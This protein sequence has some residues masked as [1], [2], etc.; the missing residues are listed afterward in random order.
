MSHGHPPRCL[1]LAAMVVLV[2]GCIP[3][4][5]GPADDDTNHLEPCVEYTATITWQQQESLLHFGTWGECGDP[6][7]PSIVGESYFLDLGSA[8]FTEPPGVGPL[9]SQYIA[10]LYLLFHILDLDDPV[11]TADLFMATVDKDGND[12]LQQMCLETTS[13]SD[14]ATWDSPYLHT[15]PGDVDLTV[16]DVE[17]PISDMEF[18]GSFEPDGK[19]MVGGTFD[20]EMDTRCLDPMI[21]PGGSEGIA[22][23]LLASLG[24][25]CQE[26]SSG[27]GTFCLLVS[28][29]GLYAEQAD[30]WAMDPET[31][32]EHET[33]IEVTAEMLE[34]WTEAGVCP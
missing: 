15:G 6:P 7:D 23:E 10:D 1:A 27:V 19:A 24:I 3:E 9:L 14:G 16:E 32:E 21:D 11:G 4:E 20:A 29:Y 18:G 2:Q 33:L 26:C 8:T 22:C 30:A 28:A 17:C 12:Y 13:L 5:P 25:E 34:A 31:G